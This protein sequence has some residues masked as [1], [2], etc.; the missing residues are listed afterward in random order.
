[1]NRW[2]A[3]CALLLAP[4]GCQWRQA[5][6]ISGTVNISPALLG[7]ARQP[8]SVL[9]IVARNRGNVPVAVREIVNPEFPC[10]FT[11]GAEDLILPRGW[12]GKIRIAAQLYTRIGPNGTPVPDAEGF[13]SEPV[14]PGT[15]S[16]RIFIGADPPSSRLASRPTPR[17]ESGNQ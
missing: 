4:S 6:P 11:I 15:D 13:Q 16:V 8:N 5:P 1:M 9:L 17:P 3:F 7:K 10:P 12:A 2:L 14:P